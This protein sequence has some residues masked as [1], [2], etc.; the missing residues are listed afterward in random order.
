[1]PIIPR[2]C[3]WEEFTDTLTDK[4]TG[5]RV[6]VQRIRCIYCPHV[7]PSVSPKTGLLKFPLDDKRPYWNC[8]NPSDLQPLADKLGV[9][10][11]ELLR[12]RGSLEEI[13]SGYLAVQ[14]AAE[15]LEI[16][17]ILGHIP[18]GIYPYLM[19][20]VK[21]G[22][23]QRE[24][25]EWDR[26][27]RGDCEHRRHSGMCGAIGC[28]KDSKRKGYMIACLWLCRMATASCPKGKFKGTSDGEEKLQTP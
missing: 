6:E 18:S 4:A 9:E 21:A 26:L 15:K 27:W 3:V 2:D 1:M 24:E 10:V 19:D 17:K 20:W 16:V 22:M 11:K 14:A 28:Q 7:F 23:P 12:Y 25:A 5:E 13:E 8:A